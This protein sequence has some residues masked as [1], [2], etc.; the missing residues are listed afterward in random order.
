MGKISSVYAD[1]IYLTDDN[2]RSENPQ[3]IRNEIKKG[4]KNKDLQ[5]ISVEKKQFSN[6]SKILSLET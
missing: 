5:E 1:K 2:P 6:V 3:K 4:I